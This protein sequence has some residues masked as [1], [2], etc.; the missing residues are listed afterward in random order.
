VGGWWCVAGGGPSPVSACSRADPSQ[1][2]GGSL[3]AQNA[4]RMGDCVLSGGGI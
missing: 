1:G 2:A 3:D 4:H